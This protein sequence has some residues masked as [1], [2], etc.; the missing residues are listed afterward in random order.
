V[1]AS[2]SQYRTVLVFVSVPLGVVGVLLAPNPVALVPMLTSVA[3]IG[4]AGGLFA[5]RQR[6]V[7]ARNVTSIA[8]VA[9]VL[10]SFSGCFVAVSDPWWVL[11]AV[12]GVWLFGVSGALF[13]AQRKGWGQ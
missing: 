10:G 9:A 6:W 7:R 11:G 12:V 4:A 3:L 5:V 2:L 8:A 13:L 1:G